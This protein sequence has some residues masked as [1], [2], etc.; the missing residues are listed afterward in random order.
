MPDGSGMAE[1]TIT[2]F[3]GFA[4]TRKTDRRLS[5]EQLIHE[6]RTTTAQSKVGLP[7]LKLARFGGIRSDK[8]SLR[9]DAN[10]LSI[11]GIEADYDGEK[12]SPEAALELLEKAGIRSLLY[13]SPSHRPEAP[14]WRV[15]CP[16]SVELTPDRRSHLVGRLNGLFGGVLSS[17]SFTLS[18]AYF[19][20]RV[21]DNPSHMAEMVDGLPI[22]L[23][24]EL[25]IAWIGRPH[26]AKPGSEA[27]HGQQ[28]TDT[29]ALYAEIV[30]GIKYYEACVRL[31]GVWARGGIP[32][33]EARRQLLDAFDAVPDDKRDARWA[34]RRTDVDR[35]IEGIYGKEAKKRDGVGDA[36]K[37]RRP[38]TSG[39][40]WKF[41][42]QRTKD[43]R[44]LNNLANALHALRHAVQVQNAFAYDEMLR[45]DMLLEAV[46]E[47]E[48]FDGPRPVRDTD[49]TAVQEWL[50]R[51]GL[52]TI[53]QA[54]V[55]QAVEARARERAFHPVRDYLDGLRWDGV[56]R[57][58]KWLSY[59]LGADHSPYTAVIGRLFLIAMVA[60]IYE[61][62]C[63]S[64]YM[65]VF[66]NEQGTKKS[67][68]CAVLAGK[69]FS[70]SLPD[71]RSAGKDVAQHLNGKWLIEVAEMSALDKADAA[72]L[73]AF[74]TR[75]VERYRPSY[76]R[77]EVIEPRQCMFI[78]TTNKTTYLRDETGGRR[79]WPVKTGAV[80]L[81]ALKHDRDQLFAEAVQLYRQGQQWWPNQEFEK[82]LIA[83][84]QEARFEPD[85]WEQAIAEYLVKPPE[86]VTVLGVAE[87]ALGL[88]KARV[89]RAEQNRVIAALERLGW[90]R[91]TRT[92]STRPWVRRVT[93]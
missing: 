87:F 54:T 39:S 38:A 73:K 30:F 29:A 65:L 12:I 83:P 71:V 22:D 5:W 14:R 51:E 63:K 53:G 77:K 31:A 85:A 17:E 13:T 7:W 16:T 26:T 74:I 10:V 40:N 88:D 91:G 78:G 93:Q 19:Y 2:C 25:D 1:I 44:P 37:P 43:K 36:A 48:D 67:Q 58:D 66:E 92:G 4:A 33:M 27:G 45:A 69:W 50:Q 80:D 3:D 42:W 61:P 20:G 28:K 34:A 35:C 76:G 79:F 6:V 41:G 62:G 84:E 15:L 82:E 46:P 11:T 32:Y 8:G 57:L 49:I 89:G 21:G 55:H 86:V 18:Q 81:E 60:R 47:V 72:A 68:A 24:D 90:V 56:L 59:Y 70:D 64:D 75:P 9:H 23:C 52:T